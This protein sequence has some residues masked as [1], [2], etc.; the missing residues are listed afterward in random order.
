MEVEYNKS[1]SSS[2]AYIDIVR[3]I[4]AS[5][6]KVLHRLEGGQKLEVSVSNEVTKWDEIYQ[7]VFTQAGIKELEM[8]PYEYSVSKTVEEKS[9]I[10]QY[11]LSFLESLERY[12]LCHLVNEN[13]HVI[14]SH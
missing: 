11:I 7:L 5:V 1:L 10:I 8:V 3:E 12:D 14:F 9:L 6:F 4:K 13:K 2:L